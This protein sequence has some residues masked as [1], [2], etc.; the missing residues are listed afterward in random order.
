MLPEF[1][2]LKI[3]DDDPASPYAALNKVGI[4]KLQRAWEA[5][6]CYSQFYLSV[7]MYGKAKEESMTEQMRLLIKEKDC[8][9]VDLE[10]QCRALHNLFL[11]FLT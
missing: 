6:Y 10:D 8:R 2:K 11:P 4:E 5:Y 3:F 9:I 7:E 1:N